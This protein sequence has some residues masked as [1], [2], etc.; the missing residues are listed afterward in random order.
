MTD[1]PGGEV[2]FAHPVE[3]ELGASS[4]S[5]IAWLYEP[6]PFVLRH[7]EEDWTVREAFS[8]D[9]YLWE[10]GVYL[11]CTVMRQA[12]TTKKR[13]KVARARQHLGIT[14]E[15]LYRRDIDRLA[16][17]WRLPALAGAARATGQV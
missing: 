12:Y 17:K 14:V 2:A 5:G 6:H 11:E 16:R 15:V 3:R 7:D 8:P 13:R 1:E 4:T 10:L 9:F